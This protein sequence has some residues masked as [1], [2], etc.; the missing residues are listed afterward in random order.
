MIKVYDLVS[1]R[2]KYKELE[3]KKVLE[4]FKNPKTYV[5]DN[6][7]Y[8][9][10]NL[11]HNPLYEKQYKEDRTSIIPAIQWNK[12]SNSEH[13]GFIYFDFDFDSYEISVSEK[14]RLLEDWNELIYSCWISLSG[15]G[16]GVLFKTDR[17]LKSQTEFLKVYDFL[18]KH[19]QQ[20]N[21]NSDPKRRD[22]SSVNFISYDPDIYINE[23]SMLFV[24]VILKECE[25][26]EK[27][28]IREKKET[29]AEV[30]RKRFESVLI[31]KSQFGWN[32]KE[33]VKEKPN[34]K[35]YYSVN[36]FAKIKVGNRGNTYS[37]V[38]TKLL[39]LNPQVEKLK[40]IKKLIIWLNEN[41][42]EKPWDKKELENF[43]SGI[44][45]LK[46]NKIQNENKMLIKNPTYHQTLRMLGELGKLNI[47]SMEQ[48]I[49]SVVT[50][51]NKELQ[52]NKAIKSGAK[53]LNEIHLKTKISKSTIMKYFKTQGKEYSELLEISN[54]KDVVQQINE[55]IHELILENEE[56]L[57]KDEI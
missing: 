40:E 41:K 39:R 51:A 9:R 21:F 35:P 12:A 33:Y 53:T 55:F 17:K 14:K 46:S 13:T 8:F 25:L 19:F 5:L 43:L 45:N 29:V 34:S 37:A 7:S 6:I 57:K 20:N 24:D 11:I 3:A 26:E 49:V 52:I 38:A 30:Q 16:L 2:N 31:L 44:E 28:L 1:D 4:Q 50:K 32:V 48:T 10:Q 22:F 18:N 23:D 42:A 47:K 56:N 36:L 54:I 15:T 27:E